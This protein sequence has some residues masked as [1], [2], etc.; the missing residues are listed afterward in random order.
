MAGNASVLNF[1]RYVSLCE[2][3]RAGA[4]YLS[5]IV[6]VDCCGLSMIVIKDVIIII[7]IIIIDYLSLAGSR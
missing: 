7:I 5:Y 2:G 1:V 3:L 6:H 4:G